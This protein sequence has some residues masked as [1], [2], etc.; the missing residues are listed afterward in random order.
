MISASRI[1][2]LSSVLAVSLLKL[3][4]LV[5]ALIEASIV[6]SNPNRFLIMQ[7]WEVLWL[8]LSIIL[9]Q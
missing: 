7:G 1:C 9:V 5:D 8:G 2:C 6:Y 4:A 3:Y